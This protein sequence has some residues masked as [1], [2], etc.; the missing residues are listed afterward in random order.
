MKEKTLDGGAQMLLQF[1]R[2]RDSNGQ[3]KM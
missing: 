2:F 1:L 3:P